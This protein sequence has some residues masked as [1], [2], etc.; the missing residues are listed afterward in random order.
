MGTWPLEPQGCPWLLSSTFDVLGT[1]LSIG[2]HFLMGPNKSLTTGATERL[3]HLVLITQ[4]E[5]MVWR[6][7]IQMCPFV[8]RQFLLPVAFCH[9]CQHHPD[10]PGEKLLSRVQFPLVNSASALL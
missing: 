5:V 1:Y 10:I 8:P 3:S 2:V 6:F 7:E 4:Q 9:F